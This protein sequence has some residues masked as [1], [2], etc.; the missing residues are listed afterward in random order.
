M[1]RVTCI[2]K[3]DRQI[4]WERI[5]RLGGTRDDTGDRWSCT[6]QECIAYI[7]SGYNFYVLKDGHR[8]NLIVAVSQ[9]GNKYVKTQTD[10]Y[11]QDNLLALPECP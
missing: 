7:E 1:N 6:Q 5:Q 2:N 4:P 3:A 10:Y 8:V 9:S 11:E